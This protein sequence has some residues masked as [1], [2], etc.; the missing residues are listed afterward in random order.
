MD[1]HLT[2]LP[3]D[4][5]NEIIKYLSPKDVYQYSATCTKAWTQMLTYWKSIAPKNSLLPSSPASTNLGPSLFW[6]RLFIKNQ[7]ILLE[8]VMSMLIDLF[9]RYPNKKI[10]KKYVQ[11]IIF[12]Q[13]FKILHHQPYLICMKSLRSYREEM[14][15][16]MLNFSRHY[17]ISLQIENYFR[18]VYGSKFDHIFSYDLPTLFGDAL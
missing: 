3:K 12:E 8:R 10:Y 13:I 7:I 1:D 14:E 4:I 11:P 5:I 9:N 6:Y 15:Y 18:K 16:Y 17:T 2:T